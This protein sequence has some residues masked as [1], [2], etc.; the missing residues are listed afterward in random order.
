M[1][2]EINVPNV[3]GQAQ[4]AAEE[5]LRSVGLSVG[6]TMLLNSDTRPKGAVISAKPAVG[7]LVLTGSPV[8]LEVSIGPAQVALPNVVGQAQS[9][10]EEML[11]SVGL[12]VGTTIGVNSDTT[13]KGAVISAKPAVGTL[14]LLGS[15][16]NLE[17][18][19]GPAQVSV[20]NVT[21]LTQLAA[22][23][24]LRSAGLLV[25]TIS[26]G[27]NNAVPAG[28]VSAVEPVA[29][30]LVRSGSPVNL[31]VSTGQKTDWTQYTTIV[32]FAVLGVIILVSIGYVVFDKKGSFLKDLANKE[33]ARGLITF[34]IAITTVSIA[35]I[36]ALSTIIL[37][38][39]EEDDK[40]FDRGKQILTMLIGVLGTI[41]GFY[42]GSAVD[43]S[44][45]APTTEQVKSAAPRIFAT[46]LP[47]GTVNVAYKTTT[48][49]ATG[50]TPPLKWSVTPELPSGLTLEETTGVISGT[51]KEAQ[52]KSLK[53]K[54][55]D[56]ADPNVASTADLTIEIK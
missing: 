49:E 4:S 12:S 56:S 38:G 40:R 34:L 39:G 7:T 18:S 25:G 28:G 37:K 43:N 44:R 30:A 36:L 31:E 14:V 16:V 53:F 5:T 22:E 41:V 11:R 2:E 26:T 46:T 29:G 51:P 52:K 21:G 20:P 9:A 15:P 47:D 27:R 54:V 23:A 3:V 50:G 1:P 13:P 32:L 42:Y 45:A 55:T 10:A 48:L 6:T 8:D 17:V 35:V 19:I 24:V 33:I